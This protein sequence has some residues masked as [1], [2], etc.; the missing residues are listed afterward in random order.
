MTRAGIALRLIL[1][2]LA[3]LIVIGPHWLSL[4]FGHGRL[5]GRMPVLFHR[6]SRIRP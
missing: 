6:L 5:A 3:F 4:R 2:A 1:Q